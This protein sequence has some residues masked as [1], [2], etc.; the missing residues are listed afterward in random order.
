MKHHDKVLKLYADNG[1]RTAQDWGTMGRDVK[2]DAKPC[3]DATSRGGKV[4]LFTRAQTQLRSQ[5]REQRSQTTDAAV[6][7]APPAAA[8][9]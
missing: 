5:T 7:A 6:T 3:A 2:A 8:G 4:S 1:M 9:E